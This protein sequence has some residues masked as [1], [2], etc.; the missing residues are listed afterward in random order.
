MRKK[1]FKPTIV[2][3]KIKSRQILSASYV[4]E[5]LNMYQDEEDEIEEEESI[6]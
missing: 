5:D 3:V 2:V 4:V 1:Y 6:W